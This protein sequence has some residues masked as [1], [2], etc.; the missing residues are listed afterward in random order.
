MSE[1][2]NNCI[3]I[4][5]QTPPLTGVVNALLMLTTPFDQFQIREPKCSYPALLQ[6]N[7]QTSSVHYK[8]DTLLSYGKT[9]KYKMFLL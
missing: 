7:A 9:T 3:G 6:V 5:S 1:F 8:S 2:D 4:E